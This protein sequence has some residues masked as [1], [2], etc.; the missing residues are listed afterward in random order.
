MD[1]TNNASGLRRDP[2]FDLIRCF[3]LLSVISTHFFLFSYFYT[4]PIIGK[5]LYL[6]TLIRTTTMVSV[7][8][9]MVLSGCLLRNKTC[10]RNYYSSLTKTL[11]I[12]ILAS[13]ICG[14]FRK[15]YLL[16][17]I[18]LKEI[19]LGFL[20]F[21]TAPY[22]WYIELYIGLF[23][24]I[25]FL[26]ILYK[27]LPQ[28]RDKQF[29]LFSCL[30]LTSLP[31][32]V[33]VYSFDSIGWWLTPSVSNSYAKLVP[34]WWTNLYPI[35]Y[36][37]LGCYLMEYRPKVKTVPNLLLILLTVFVHGSYCYWRTYG[38]AFI[39]GA[40]AAYES[41]PV[42]LL[43]TLV[44]TFFLNLD[45]SHAPLF[46]A[47]ILKTVSDCCLGG[48]LVSYIFDEIFYRWLRERVGYMPDRLKYFFIIIPLIFLCSIALS[49]II[50]LIYRIGAFLCNRRNF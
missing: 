15:Y 49:W 13:I 7:P 18:S 14:G 34:A 48:Y 27:N 30:C 4:E 38:V 50:N 26:N 21:Q 10:S 40:W 42:V 28:K 6:F 43:T 33:N 9:F 12:Y 36:Y 23:L 8:M 35:T 45:L 19:L 5:K 47:G 44:Y 25:P 1:Q 17:P 22:G 46:W 16:E 11:V 20:S 41:L 39:D 3:A 2:R 37:F 24:L 32:I 31:G 29:L